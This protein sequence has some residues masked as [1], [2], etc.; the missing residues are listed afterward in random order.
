M[1]LYL[2]FLS[3]GLSSKTMKVDDVN[4]LLD[5]VPQQGYGEHDILFRW[6]RVACEWLRTLTSADEKTFAKATAELKDHCVK[7][8]TTVTDQENTIW[9]V[10]QMRAAIAQ[11]AERLDSISYADRFK[12]KFKFDAALE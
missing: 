12:V 8:V 5:D 11:L 3:L 9:R 7:F 10:D 6:L 1:S 4:V 2:R